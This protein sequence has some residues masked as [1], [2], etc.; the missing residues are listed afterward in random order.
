MR[1]I[2]ERPTRIEA[3]GDSGALLFIDAE[4]NG[5]FNDP[6]DVLAT[7]IIKGGSPV[8]SMTGAPKLIEL[9]YQALVPLEGEP[10][11]IELQRAAGTTDG[12][13]TTDV[14]D[15]IVPFQQPT[16]EP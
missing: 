11:H 7:H 15:R 13:W 9:R 14:V 16:P 1:A 4:G 12:E 5:D 8:I 6:G 2:A 10:I 3:Y